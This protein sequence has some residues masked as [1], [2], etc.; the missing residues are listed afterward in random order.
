MVLNKI[1]DPVQ[2]SETNTLKL[3]S[4]QACQCLVIVIY[5]LV[6]AVFNGKKNF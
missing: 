5:A 2:W 1:P 3:K 6:Y 4:L